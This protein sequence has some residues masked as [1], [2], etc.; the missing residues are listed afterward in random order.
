VGQVFES[1]IVVS[2]DIQ[3]NTLGIYFDSN[4]QISKEFLSANNLYRD[5]TLNKDTTKSG[6]FD[7]NGRVKCLKLRGVKSDAFW[8]PVSSLDFTSNKTYTLNEGFEFNEFNQIPICRKYINKKTRQQGN[9]KSKVKS[10]DKIKV[11]KLVFPEHFDTEQ[12]DRNIQNIPDNT[13]IVLTWKLHGT[14]VRTS[15]TKIDINPTKVKYYLQKLLNIFKL[16]L[17]FSEYK[18]LVG[19][20]KVI[21][22]DL[23]IKRNLYLEDFWLYKKIDVKKSWFKEF[24]VSYYK[25]DMPDEVY[26]NIFPLGNDDSDIYNT[27]SFF[28]NKLGIPLNTF[29][30]WIHDNYYIS[31]T[32]FYKTDIWSKATECL[33]GKLHKNEM[34]YAEIVGYESENT[35][36]MGT[37][38]TKKMDSVDKNFRKQYGDNMV[39]SYGCKPGEYK[40]F[41][42]RISLLNLD[43]YEY[44]YNWEDVKRRCAELGVS[45]VPEIKTMNTHEFYED[46]RKFIE[47]VES[48]LD[49]PSVLDSSHLEEGVVV[50]V[51]NG[52]NLKAYKMKGFLY[53]YLEG[54]IKDN[55]N[56]V[57]IEESQ[58]IEEAEDA[59]S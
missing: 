41:I 47:Y 45:Y 22:T 48:L 34:V 19:S 36:L 40:L 11:S 10:E 21:K 52:M 59:H 7:E 56:F 43:G 29:K 51:E 1:N 54:I 14:S 38:N 33:K 13:T 5:S 20:R 31:N 9:R 2:K 57:D 55:E 28:D 18:E 8:I 58:S 16:K 50:R 23:V 17:D 44:D 12:L 35:P 46:K 26:R 3:E 37:Y 53:K 42:Y 15:Y 25:V 32:G 30:T 39:F 6:F 27:F 24:Y 49:K 4:L